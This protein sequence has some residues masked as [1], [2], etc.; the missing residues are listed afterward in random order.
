MS[1]SKV[2]YIWLDGNEPTIASEIYISQIPIS[3]SI[4]LNASV[5]TLTLIGVFIH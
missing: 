4:E 5:F 1:R 2:E 3:E